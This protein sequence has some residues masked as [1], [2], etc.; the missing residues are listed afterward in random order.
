MSKTWTIDVLIDTDYLNTLSKTGTWKNPVGGGEHFRN[1][2]LMVASC[3]KSKEVIAGNDDNFVLTVKKGD[4]IRWVC[5]PM[6]P[7]ASNGLT[8]CLYDFKKGKN[9][10]KYLFPPKQDAEQ[11]ITIKLPDAMFG[12]KEEPALKRL[13][14]HGDDIGV[15]YVKVRKLTELKLPATITY[16][17]KVI[18]FEITPIHNDDEEEP[19]SYKAEP[20]NYIQIDP[21][22]KIEK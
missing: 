4:T 11:Y 17:M 7:L 9:W 2:V 5:S 14:A 21:K 12:K 15:P 13:I 20:I 19:K 10:S 22:I 6:D 3:H 18:L 1:H 8:V 16:H